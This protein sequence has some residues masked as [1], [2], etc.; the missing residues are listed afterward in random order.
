MD[1]KVVERTLHVQEVAGSNLER[2]EHI[3]S[4]IIN[5]GTLNYIKSEIF[6]YPLVFY[7]I[8]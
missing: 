6:A 5:V 4:G 7:T 1:S 3:L 8:R 2:G